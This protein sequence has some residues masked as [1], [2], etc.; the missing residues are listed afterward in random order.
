MEKTAI[1]FISSQS[2]IFSEAQ[3]EFFILRN[4]TGLSIKG[5]IPQCLAPS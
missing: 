3:A 4:N 1:F 2:R 5:L